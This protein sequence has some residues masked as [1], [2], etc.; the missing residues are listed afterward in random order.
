LISSKIESVQSFVP[1][2]IKANISIQPKYQIYRD[3]EDGTMAPQF[4][5]SMGHFKI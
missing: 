2:L 4:T 5:I 3:W 1:A